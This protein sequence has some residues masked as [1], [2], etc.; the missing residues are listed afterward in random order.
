MCTERPSF[1]KELALYVLPPEHNPLR[2]CIHKPDGKPIFRSHV[3]GILGT[4]I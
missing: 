2:K 1:F 4:Q 3:G